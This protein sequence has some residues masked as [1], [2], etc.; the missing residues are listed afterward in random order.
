MNPRFIQLPNGRA[1]TLD[2]YAKAWKKL[3]TLNPDTLVSGW[4]HFPERAGDIL[5]AMSAGL[6][7][8]I[9]RHIP[10]FGI[11]RKWSEDWQRECVYTAA[12][13]RNP[14]LA[15]DWLPM[16]LKKRLSHRLREREAE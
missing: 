1:V 7:D 6:D 2:A 14:R 13:L 8:R 15:I 9:N 5:R 4:S 11:G 12:L 3:R 16:D 10:G